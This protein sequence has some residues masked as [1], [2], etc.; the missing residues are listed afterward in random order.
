MP[1]KTSGAP[2][3]PTRAARYLAS[4]PWYGIVT[5]STSYP[6]FWANSLPFVSYHLLNSGFCS[7]C[8]QNTSFLDCA[9][10]GAASAIATASA[11]TTTTASPL[12][13]RIPA[14]LPRAE[15]VKDD[16]AG[17]ILEAVRAGCQAE[18][19]RSW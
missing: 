17:A 6:D 12:N 8:V 1:R 9:A 2:L 4:Y 19:V 18:G 5:T 10:P 3:F 7:Q 16:N 13:V 14:P 11:P 15:R